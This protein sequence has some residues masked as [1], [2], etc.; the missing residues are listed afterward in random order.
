MTSSPVTVL[1]DTVRHSTVYV[2]VSVCVCIYIY[3]YIYIYI[4][5]DVIYAKVVPIYYMFRLGRATIRYVYKC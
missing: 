2:Y 1:I 3:I 4:A 5:H